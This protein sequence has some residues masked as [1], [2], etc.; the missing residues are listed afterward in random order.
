MRNLYF[1]RF[2]TLLL[3]AA[4]FVLT[5]AVSCSKEEEAKPTQGKITGTAVPAAALA[6]VTATDAS[7]ASTTVTPNSSSGEFSI[8]NLTAGTYNLHFAAASGYLDPADRSVSVAAGETNNVGS[9]QV[10]EYLVGR[11][12][13]TVNPANSLRYIQLTPPGSQNGPMVQ[14]DVNGYFVFNNVA[15]GTYNVSFDPAS[16]FLSVPPRTVTVTARNTTSMGT[17]NVNPAGTNSAT[18][19]GTVRW[20]EGGTTYTS[21]SATGSI[22]LNNGAPDTFSLSASSQ[23]GNVSDVL[24]LYAYAGRTGTY[25]MDNQVYSP[26]ATYLR[27]AGGVPLNSYETR[28][29]NSP[30]G[31]VTITAVDP[32][33]RTVSGTFGFTA[34]EAPLRTGRITITNG[35]FT[36]SY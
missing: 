27:T 22:S 23:A 18:L 7:G 24:G 14:P 29:Q 36:L 8:A 34:A 35:S 31:S 5:T 30:A 11:V 2:W 13:G 15:P 16:G 26:S 32:V 6:S 33:A 1:V 17:I 9:I 20:T 4:G 3:F 12:D 21:N 28:Y 10:S 25:L 19:R